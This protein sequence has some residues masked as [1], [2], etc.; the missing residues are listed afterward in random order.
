MF[1]TRGDSINEIIRRLFRNV[2]YHVQT[3][4]PVGLQESSNLIPKREPV[5]WI[6]N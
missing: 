3:Q 6:E 1:L 2:R 5:L 4:P